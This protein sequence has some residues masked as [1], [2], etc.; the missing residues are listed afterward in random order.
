M[1]KVLFNPYASNGK[2][3]EE[4]EKVLA[5]TGEAETRLFNMPDTD[6]GAFFDALSAEDR[7]VI[8]GGDGTLNRFV[9]DTEGMALP[10]E[11]YYYATGTGNDFLLDIGFGRE[12]GIRE[13]GRYL[14]D[15]PTVEVNGERRRFL[16]N[17]G[18]GIDGYCTEVGDE[19][20]K[21]SDKP[22]NYAG[23]AIK[24]VLGGFHPVNASVTVDGTTVKYEKVWLA[25]TMNGR[26]YG[27]G[28]KPAPEQDRLD[29]ERTLSLFV[30]HGS[31]VLKTLTAFPSIFK[32]EHLKHTGMCTVLTG[33]DITVKFDRPTPLQIDGETVSG[34]TAYHAVSGPVFQKQ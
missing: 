20:Q 14:R 11:I 24:G 3:R 16:N 2:G 22:V 26:Y 17:V 12:D 32:G 13:I 25:P 28:M 31:G 33:H 30:W 27:G 4:A 23:I 6:Y 21:Q 19:L 15:L 29:P 9:N 10:E 8:C 7:L 18:F 5:L 1:Y 34:V